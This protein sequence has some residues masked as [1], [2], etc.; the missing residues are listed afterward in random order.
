MKDKLNIK[1]I[2]VKD[3]IPSVFNPRKW[4]DKSIA[5]LTESIKKYGLIDPLLVNSSENRKNILIGGHFR[6]KI[7]KEKKDVSLCKSI[8]FN[9]IRRV[10]EEN[11]KSLES[12]L[13][14]I[15]KQKKVLTKQIEY[16]IW[17]ASVSFDREVTMDGGIITKDIKEYR[18]C[19]T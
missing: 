4:N 12:V 13:K 19:F 6:L 16:A 2:L 15:L 1:Y 7:A 11:F 10:C 5:D 8:K 18:T 17:G 9:E 14:K 3:L